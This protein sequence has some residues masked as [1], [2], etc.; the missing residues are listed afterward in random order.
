MTK[1]EK[2]VLNLLQNKRYI[3]LKLSDME[4]INQPRKVLDKTEWMHEN[5]PELV[6]NSLIK[7]NQ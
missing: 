6:F 7:S 3:F 2:M 5:D 4:Y 1:Q